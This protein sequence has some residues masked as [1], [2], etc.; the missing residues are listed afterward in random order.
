MKNEKVFYTQ[1]IT[2]SQ[3]TNT[4]RPTWCWII[5]D[6]NGVALAKS[7]VKYYSKQKATQAAVYYD[8]KLNFRF[9][10]NVWSSTKA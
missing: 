8:N 1:Y 9:I 6:E 3:N 5:R 2:V 10:R 7:V 4:K